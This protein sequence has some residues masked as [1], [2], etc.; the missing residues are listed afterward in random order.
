MTSSECPTPVAS[1]E[2]S[3]LENEG[4]SPKVSNPSTETALKMVNE[5][6]DYSDKV[7]S[8]SLSQHERRHQLQVHKGDMSR[9]NNTLP[10][11]PSVAAS[12][13]VITTTLPAPP[14]FSTM[15]ASGDSKHHSLKEYMTETKNKGSHSVMDQ[16]ILSPPAPCATPIP[17]TRQLLTEKLTVPSKRKD[18]TTTSP[19]APEF[20]TKDASE[21]DSQFRSTKKFMTETKNTARQSPGDTDAS[22]IPE[23]QLSLAD[24]PSKPK[25]IKTYIPVPPGFSA[26]TASEGDPQFHSSTKNTTEKKTKV[27]QSHDNTKKSILPP[28]ATAAPIKKE[29]PH[30]EKIPVPPKQAHAPKGALYSWCSKRYRSY[31]KGSD[32]ITFDDGKRDHEKRFSCVFVD[33]RT[34]ECF[35]SGRYGNEYWVDGRRAGD[36]TA[37]SK[38]ATGLIWFAT[39]RAAENGA[40]A[41]AYD[42]LTYRYGLEKNQEYEQMGLDEPAAQPSVLATSLIPPSA[43]ELIG[44]ARN[45]ARTDKSG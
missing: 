21:K 37:T 6:V 22:P 31:P 20:S 28:S 41:W 39:K 38:Q 44:R 42:C 40:A 9:G 23:K 25:D 19:V 8:E 12:N 45:Q 35:P 15:A 5:E 33:P 18:M 36:F 17:E 10:S 3:N 11:Q 2:G 29:N 1:A 14:G 16:N 43:L 13:R 7:V 30:P 27:Y 32:Y 34:G 26:K 4:A 24:D